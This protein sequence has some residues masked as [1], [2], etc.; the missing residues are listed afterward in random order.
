MILLGDLQSPIP[1]PLNLY[2]SAIEPDL[3]LFHTTSKWQIGASIHAPLY[4][5]AFP[6]LKGC[7]VNDDDDNDDDEMAY[8]YMDSLHDTPRGAELNDVMTDVIATVN[9]III[10]HVKLRIFSALCE[11]MGSNHTA[12]LFHSESRWLSNNTAL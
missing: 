2:S 12:V 4:F 10:R 7:M 11:E 5:N 8:V 1:Y 9:Y 3:Q 6:M